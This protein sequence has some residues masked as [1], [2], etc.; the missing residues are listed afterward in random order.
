MARLL[1]LYYDCFSTP[2]QWPALKVVEIFF[3]V[4][5][6]SEMVVLLSPKGGLVIKKL[7]MPQGCERLSWPEQS[8]PVWQA[9]SDS[10]DLNKI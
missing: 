9:S 3:R 10:G 4:H 2:Y 7:E 1:P 6:L 8:S 5:Q